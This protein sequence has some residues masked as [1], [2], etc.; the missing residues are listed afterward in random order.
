MRVEKNQAEDQQAT[1][2]C[3]QRVGR[4]TNLN[5]LIGHIVIALIARFHADAF[6]NEHED[7]HR[8]YERGKP[9]MQLSYN[10]DNKPAVHTGNGR[11]IGCS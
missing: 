8:Q 11:V 9:E 2:N 1:E 10:P 5:K 7:G 3:S 6:N 4:D